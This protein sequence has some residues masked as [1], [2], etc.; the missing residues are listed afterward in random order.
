M[1]FNIFCM[2]CDGHIEQ[3][4]RFNTEK[5]K[6]GN[7]LSTPIFS[8]CMRHT[9]T[10]YV[11]T[12][13]AKKKAADDKLAPGVIKIHDPAKATLEDPFARAE[14]NVEDKTVVKQGAARIAELKE[15]SD[16]QWADPYEHLRKM[17]RVFR[18]EREVLNEKAAEAK[19]IWDRAGLLI[20]LLKMHSEQNP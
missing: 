6:V 15:L 19:A 2:T 3:A 9:N 17:R 18:A 11:V 16:R 4:I 8:F 7:Q 10:S 14:M 5:Q 13:G 1:P 12:E 20:E